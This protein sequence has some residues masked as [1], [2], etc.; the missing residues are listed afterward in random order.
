MTSGAYAHHMETARAYVD[1]FNLYYGAL[2][3]SPHR[4]L[5]LHRWAT[6]LMPGYAVDK[7]VYC[8]ARVVNRPSDPS[9]STRQDAYLRALRT[10][11]PRVQIEEG[12][13][14]VRPKMARR[15]ATTRCVCCDGTLLSPCDCCDGPLVQIEK[16]EEKGSDV[17]LAVNLVRDAAVGA[18]NAALVVSGDSDIQG[19][20]DVARGF[21]VTVAVADPRNGH[22]LQGDERR[23][24]R[25]GS[26]AAA[27]FPD[28]LSDLEGRVVKRPPTW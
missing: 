5:D 9:A 20:V 18:M 2:R 11:T 24:V 19:A 23:R 17:N 22:S 28:T 21:G 10:L 8:T 4:W 1:G 12:L 7:V 14:T 26:L 3:K 13:F 15:M 16:T 25:A 27:Q 6:L